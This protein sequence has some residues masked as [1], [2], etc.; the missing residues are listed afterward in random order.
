MKATVRFTVT[1]DLNRNELEKYLN[2]YAS[3]I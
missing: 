1:C 3:I 2:I